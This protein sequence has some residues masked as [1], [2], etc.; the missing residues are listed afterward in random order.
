MQIEPQSFI[1]WLMCFGTGSPAVYSIRRIEADCDL[2]RFI[3]R[4]RFSECVNMNKFV[5]I[6][7]A[8]GAWPI[9]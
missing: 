7:R 9:T 5:I 4:K 2:S 6:G 3:V 8:A 1:V